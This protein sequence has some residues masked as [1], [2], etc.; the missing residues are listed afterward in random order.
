MTGALVVL[1]AL[2]ASACA[3]SG[4]SDGGATVAK[5]ATT[6]T[7]AP[8]TTSTTTLE[9]RYAAPATI[10]PE[11]VDEVLIALNEVYGGVVRKYIETKRFEP[12]GLVTLR[13]IYSEN[14]V[15][16]S[17]FALTRSA[18]KPRDQYPATIGTRRVTVTRLM[19]V[20]P[21]CVSMEAT[22][23]FSAVN[24]HPPAPSQGW[25]A[26][27]PKDAGADPQGLNHTPWMIAAE[28]FHAEDTCA[29]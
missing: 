17:G 7:S 2:G 16:Q 21:D 15:K 6:T 12:S 23:D 1:A 22:F 4:A 8:A 3:R 28:E 24:L 26:L 29:A 18:P 20:R 27:R 9:Q 5:A 13:S 14:E 25:L 11:Y 19:T 10:T